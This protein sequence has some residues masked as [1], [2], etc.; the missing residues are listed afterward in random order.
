VSANDQ[1]R[2]L[3]EWAPKLR[4]AGI[5]TVEVEGIRATLAPHEFK[6]PEVEADAETDEEQF[7]VLNDPATYGHTNADLVPGRKQRKR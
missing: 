1:I 5:L 2:L 6:A 7:D 3:V 4:E